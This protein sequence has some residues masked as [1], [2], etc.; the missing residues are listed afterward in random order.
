MSYP[1]RRSFKTYDF[2]RSRVSRAP[3]KPRK[4]S[5][6]VGSLAVQ[7][8]LTIQRGLG[9]SGLPSRKTVTLHYAEEVSFAGAAVPLSY[10]FRLNSCNDPYYLAGGHQPL[11][12]DQWS[13]LYGHY[14]VTKS[15]ISATSLMPPTVASVDPAYL[16]VGISMSPTNI[17]NVNTMIESTMYSDP[18]QIGVANFEHAQRT[19]KNSCDIAK[20]VGVKDAL[21]DETLGADIGVDPNKE[22]YGLVSISPVNGNTTGAHKILVRLTM[23]VVFTQPKQLAAS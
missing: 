12:F 22:V 1:L 17:T 18:K 10:A 6:S 9:F 3:R 7:P 15:T 8:K 4:R 20:F 2:K 23:E 19:V 21:D 14:T 11:G 5:P 16:M 13:A